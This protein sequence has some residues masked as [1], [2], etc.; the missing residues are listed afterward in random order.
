MKPTR[1]EVAGPT[2]LT[3]RLFTVRAE[4]TKASRQRR[5][6]RTEHHATTFSPGARGAHPDR[7]ARSRA[8]DL[9]GEASQS[10]IEA[11]CRLWRLVTVASCESGGWRVLGGAYPDAL[12]I[13]ASN[14]EQFGGKPESVGPV[15]LA[16]RIVEIR[17]ADRLIAHYH[18][19]IPD[20]YGCAAW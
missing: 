5:R 14:Y 4:V 2:V 17:V 6:A 18:V 9:S 10:A 15:S 8:G 12:G 11:P 3:S 13:T 16:H 20:R 19:G 7:R 1:Q